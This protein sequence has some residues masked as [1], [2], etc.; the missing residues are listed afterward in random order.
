[1]GLYFSSCSCEGIWK[2]PKTSWSCWE[3]GKLFSCPLPETTFLNSSL[4]STLELGVNIFWALRLTAGAYSTIR[5][6]SSNTNRHNSLKLFLNWEFPWCNYFGHLEWTEDKQTF[7]FDEFNL[8][9]NSVSASSKVLDIA[10][11]YKKRPAPQGKMLGINWDWATNETVLRL[12]HCIALEVLTNGQSLWF[13][14]VKAS[15]YC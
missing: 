11:N 1:M 3:D 8:K 5:P 9:E 12:F 4:S 10:W 15:P 14:H 2:E 6:S 13:L 7:S